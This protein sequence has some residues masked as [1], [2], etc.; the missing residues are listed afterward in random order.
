MS[1]Y[2]T[3]NDL[4]LRYDVDLIGD[5]ATDDRRTLDRD[6]IATNAVVAA[7]LSEASGQINSAL[8]VGGA[9]KPAD[10]AGLTGIDADYL[11]GLVCDLAMLRLFQRRPEATPDYA[12]AIRARVAEL[13]EMLRIGRNVFNLAPTVDATILDHDGPTA[14]ALS[15]RNGLAERMHRYFPQPASRLP[16]AQGGE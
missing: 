8:I 4:I 16:K 1:A 10:L 2:A 13:L 11:A 5:L 14:V 7:A 3:G 6:E 9:Y 15:D 12:E